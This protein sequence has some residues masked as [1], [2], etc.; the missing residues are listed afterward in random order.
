MKAEDLP[1]LFK[2]CDKDFITFKGPTVPHIIWKEKRWISYFQNALVQFL[3][4]KL[5][6]LHPRM[7]GEHSSALEVLILGQYPTVKLWGK[8]SVF[9]SH[10]PP[11]NSVGVRVV[12]LLFC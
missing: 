6:K 5:Q 9:G 11:L 4:N 12:V 10:S 3:F 7:N 1:L 2:E 8:D